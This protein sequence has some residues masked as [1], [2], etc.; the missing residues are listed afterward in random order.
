M[1]TFCVNVFCFLKLS[2]LWSDKMFKNFI[3]HALGR[4]LFIYLIPL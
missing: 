4:G 2:Q 1:A 3:Q